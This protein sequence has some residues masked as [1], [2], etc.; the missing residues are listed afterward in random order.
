[1]TTRDAQVSMCLAII[2][3]ATGGRPYDNVAKLWGYMVSSDFRIAL[4]NL[5]L[6]ITWLAC[7]GRGAAVLRPYETRHAPIFYRPTLTA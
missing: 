5:L 6:E 4:C 3:R 7:P 1:M 2:G